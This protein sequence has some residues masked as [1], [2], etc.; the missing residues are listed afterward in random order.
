MKL[1]ELNNKE[2]VMIYL[3]FQDDLEAYNKVLKENGITYVLQSPVGDVSIFKELSK[4]QR[5]EIE[6][7]VKLLSS[8]VEKIHPV[9]D[10]IEDG[11]PDVIENVRDLLFPNRED[12]IDV[13]EDDEEEEEGL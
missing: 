3:T 12:D 4:E 13:E 10:I 6:P 9:F 8:I 5:A 1:T 11:D 2:L 7:K